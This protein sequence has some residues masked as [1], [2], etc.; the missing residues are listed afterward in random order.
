VAGCFGR[1]SSIENPRVIDG[2]IL[3]YALKMKQLGRTEET[4]KS[5]IQVLS[6]FSKMVDITQPEQ[7]Q[8]LLSELKWKNSTKN[9]A[10]RTYTNFLKFLGIQ[11]EKPEYTNPRE[12][13]F[14]PTEAEV[15]M[16]ITG[17]RRG[18]TPILL[19]LL[20]ETAARLGEAAHLKWTNIDYERKT[21]YIKAEKGSNSRILP[22]SDKL[23]AMI[24]TLPQT[25]ETI[26]ATSKES[27]RRVFEVARNRVAKRSHNPRLRQIHLHTLRHWKATMEYHKTKDII[28]V[29]TFLGH[30]SIESTMVYINVEAALWLQSTDTWPCRVAHNEQEAIHLIEA[31]FTYVNNL[32]DQCALYKKLK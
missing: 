4:I 32:G 30:K 10:I 16:L 23:I 25:N 15:D 14:I 5:Q 19:Q 1:A 22:I 24:K 29:K 28:H 2:R 20:K 21:V 26:F 27:L 7:V 6:Q 8:N 18:K 9:K 3:N 11:W 17:I 12:I 13:A 31:G